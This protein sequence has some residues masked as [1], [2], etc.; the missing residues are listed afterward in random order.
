MQED[1][2]EFPEVEFILKNDE[3]NGEEL[4]EEIKE[5][6]KRRETPSGELITP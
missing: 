6:L 5:M 2:K 1:R 4:E 3:K